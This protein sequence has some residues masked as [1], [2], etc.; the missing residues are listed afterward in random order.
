MQLGC[1]HPQQR[2]RCTAARPPG[3]ANTA[4]AQ[5]RGPGVTGEG[6][7]EGTSFVTCTRHE[8]HKE[9]WPE[10]SSPGIGQ[11]GL[12]QGRRVSTCTITSTQCFKTYKQRKWLCHYGDV[13]YFYSTLE[14]IC[15]P[16]LVFVTQ[17]Q[18]KRKHQKITLNHLE[19][20]KMMVNDVFSRTHEILGR[21]L[22]ILFYHHLGPLIE[23]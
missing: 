5:V 4:W 15:V 14:Y 7:P 16:S 13:L 3:G 23:L 20:G 18:L 17:S 6:G 1:C 2:A 8:R 11:N 10:D 19:G 12:K 9:N 22:S 21:S